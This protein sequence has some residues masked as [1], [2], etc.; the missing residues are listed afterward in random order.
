MIILNLED[1]QEIDTHARPLYNADFYTGRIE[2]KIQVG[3]TFIMIWVDH[4]SMKE[5]Q[6]QISELHI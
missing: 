5:I 4:K 3:N 2:M 6:K 1:N